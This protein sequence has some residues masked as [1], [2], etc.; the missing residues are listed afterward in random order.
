MSGRTSG[1]ESRT[2]VRRRQGGLPLRSGLMQRVLEDAAGRLPGPDTQCLRE[3]RLPGVPG[4]VSPPTPRPL[5][6]GRDPRA[7]RA[8]C[9]TPAS[10]RTCG[11]TPR[12]HCHTQHPRTRTQASSPPASWLPPPRA[13]ARTAVRCPSTAAARLGRSLSGDCGEKREATTYLSARD[14]TTT[15]TETLP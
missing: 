7:P 9:P 8:D 3:T 15:T 4:R 14:K 10:H 6:S 11:P 12:T 13:R 1:Q 2:E 5:L